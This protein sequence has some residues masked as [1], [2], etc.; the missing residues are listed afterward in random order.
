MGSGG[1]SAEARTRGKVYGL[2]AVAFHPPTTDAQRVWHDL[3]ELRSAI[4]PEVN[5]TGTEGPTHRSVE[6]DALEQEYNRLFVGPGRV[7]CPPYESVYRGGINGS[8]S[9]QVL[10]QASSEV[11]ARYRE[12]GLGLASDFTDLPDHVAVELEFM[13]F[14]CDQES[15]SVGRGGIE[16]RGQQARFLGEHM[17]KW[18]FAFAD[19]VAKNTKSLYYWTAAILLEEFLK[20]EGDFLST[21]GGE[22]P[23]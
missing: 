8:K 23:R 5:E 3:N 13:K 4:S 7:I 2:L 19:S 9:G 22:L 11:R 21:E 18:V 6:F 16:R 15:D 17:E 14:L 10:G 20:D 1:A 12:A